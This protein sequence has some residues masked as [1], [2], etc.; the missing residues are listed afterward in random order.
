MPSHGALQRLEAGCVMFFFSTFLSAVLWLTTC[1]AV[2][3]SSDRPRAYLRCWFGL[4]PVGFVFL[5]AFLTIYLLHAVLTG[6]LALACRS[7]GAGP[8][9]FAL[10]SLA[11]GLIS[12]TLVAIPR[13]VELRQLAEKYPIESLDE[14]LAYEPPTGRES[15]AVSSVYDLINGRRS[16]AS[17]AE[18][19]YP[20]V[21]PLE[22]KRR[23]IALEDLHTGC[24]RLF[25]N[26]PGFGVARTLYFHTQDIAVP[27]R[28]PIPLPEPSKPGYGPA[29]S[30]GDM[31]S[32][33]G[34]AAEPS[35]DVR[36]RLVRMHRLGRFDF[37]NP[38]GFGY[39]P[40]RRRSAGF[41]SHAF[42][43][44]P[45]LSSDKDDDRW[46]VDK[47]ELVSLL[48]HNEPVVYVSDHLPR[49]A[50]LR[51]APTRPLD[52]FEREQ[53]PRLFRGDDLAAVP[54]PRRIR[55]LGAIRAF[56]ECLNCHNAAEK[57]LLGA[58]SYDLRLDLPPSR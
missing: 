39:M 48:R 2:Y 4:L 5:G 32:V 12:Y 44:M 14:R 29:T 31:L 43:F 13:I 7:A 30:S 57:D 22:I 46:R 6:V 10:G 24:V 54:A 52:E 20:L 8:R 49:M 26:S 17:D 36:D 1:L 33:E 45:S 18:D 51:T 47:L 37:L 56:E 40:E 42:R 28:P 50:E 25:N 34:P 15:Q 35:A 27:E 53:L 9:A 19:Y 3:Y 11:A 41:Q 21:F 38:L 58:F 23:V 16:F 55:M